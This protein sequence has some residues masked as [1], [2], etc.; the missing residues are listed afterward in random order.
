MIAETQS[1]RS[2]ATNGCERSRPSNGGGAGPNQPTAAE[3]RGG[4]S[5][6]GARSA[7]SE[8]AKRTI[9][10][11]PNVAALGGREW[12]DHGGTG[13]TAGFETRGNKADTNKGGGGQKASARERRPRAA[14]PHADRSG[15]A[16]CHSR[17]RMNDRAW[18]SRG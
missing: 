4:D 8:Q 6:G 7:R 12:A 3:D 10:R 1:R 5:G 9:A 16:R 2:E 17:S 18:R 11:R 15:S 13:G 14:A